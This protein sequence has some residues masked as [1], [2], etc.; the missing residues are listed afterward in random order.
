VE[1]F[2]LLFGQSDFLLVYSRMIEYYEKMRSRH[3]VDW[4]GDALLLPSFP[5]WLPGLMKQSRS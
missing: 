5:S 1:E 2:A 3:V 4:L